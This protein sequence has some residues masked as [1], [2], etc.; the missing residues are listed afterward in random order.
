MSRLKSAI[1]H[2]LL[3]RGFRPFFLLG[4]LYA[5][6]SLIIWAGIYSDYIVPIDILSTP[7]AW[8]AHEMIYG[9]TIAIIAGFLLTAVANW[10]GGS[11]VRQIHLAS[12]CLLWIA[13]RIVMNIELGLPLWLTYGIASAFLP[14]LA[15]SLSIPLFKS[16]NVRNFIFLLL[17][18]SLSICQISFFVIE[19]QTPLYVAL[20]IIMIIISLI[21]GRIIPAFTVAAIRRAGNQVFQTDQKKMDIAALISLISLIIALLTVGVNHWLFGIAGLISA[22]IHIIRMRH[23]H[24][25]L[26]FNDPMVW[27]LHVGYFWLIIGLVLMGLSGFGFLLFST[28]LHAITVGCIGSMTL[29]MMC[30]VA[31]GHTGRELKASILTTLI[32]I[33]IQITALIRILG[34]WLLPEQAIICIISSALLWAI[35]YG[36]Y[37]VVYTP[38]LFSSRPDGR[39]A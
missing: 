23:Y 19:E 17:L 37:L 7:I 39:P 12:L 11:P 29:G 34:V 18:S 36:L 27:I 4:A 28:A 2:P 22:S 15:I 3:G 30:R 21:G 32:F 13:G 5:A 31:L 1:E 14:A 24:T 9:F 35:S 6:L 26:T 8:H 38:I 16:R 20:I 25:K 33:T 10:T